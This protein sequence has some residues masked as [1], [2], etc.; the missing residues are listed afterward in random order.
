M[1]IK[2]FFVHQL[3]MGTGLDDFPVMEHDDIIGDPG[4]AEPVSDDDGSAILGQVK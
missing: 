3:G 4:G 2:S 1:V